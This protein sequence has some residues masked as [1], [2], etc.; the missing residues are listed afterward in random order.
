MISKLCKSRAVVSFCF[1]LLVSATVV[2]GF[3]LVQ[4]HLR[5]VATA[6]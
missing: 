2:V 4:P 3:K 1:V 6:H 5:C